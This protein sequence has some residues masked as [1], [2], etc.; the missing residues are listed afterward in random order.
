MLVSR[1]LACCI[2]AA[3]RWWPHAVSRRCAW[4]TSLPSTPSIHHIQ[5]APFTTICSGWIECVL[6]GRAHH[7][8]FQWCALFCFA[9]S[10][11]SHRATPAPFATARGGQKKASRRRQCSRERVVLM[12]AKNVMDHPRISS[13]INHTMIHPSKTLLTSFYANDTPHT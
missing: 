8:D 12:M 3:A 13:S 5:E 11:I 9:G 1:W 10:C 6:C 4:S 7:L 2:V